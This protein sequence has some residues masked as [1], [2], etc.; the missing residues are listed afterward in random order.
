MKK[1]LIAI[2]EIAAVLTGIA[3]LGIGVKKLLLT[4]RDPRKIQKSDVARCME[5]IASMYDWGD[6][7]EYT[8]QSASAS[9]TGKN[10]YY[11][12]AVIAWKDNS[13]VRYE[14]FCTCEPDGSLTCEQVTKRGK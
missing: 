9:T 11:L 2:A 7:Y 1:R 5:E 14:F 10:R 13:P 4:E 6:S 12:I 8:V 3:A